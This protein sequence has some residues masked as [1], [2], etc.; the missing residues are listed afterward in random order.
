[1]EQIQ[2]KVLQLNRNGIVQAQLF[3]TRADNGVR[4]LVEVFKIALDR[5]LAEQH[6]HDRKHDH[7]RDRRANKSAQNITEQYIT[8]NP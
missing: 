7:Q 1:M 4:K 6:K 8:S 5:H 3:K 2:E